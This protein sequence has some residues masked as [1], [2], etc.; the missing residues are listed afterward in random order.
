VKVP[1]MSMPIRQAIPLPFDS[2]HA[3][4]APDLIDWTARPHEAQGS[5]TRPLSCSVPVL[6]SPW[7]VG[8]LW[9]EFRLWMAAVT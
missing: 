5:L 9:Y 2:V 7:N 1:P 8:R 4:A 6:G 3:F